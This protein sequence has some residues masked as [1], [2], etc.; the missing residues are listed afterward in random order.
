MKIINFTLCVFALLASGSRLIEGPTSGAGV[1]QNEFNIIRADKGYVMGG[2]GET[3]PESSQIVRAE[4]C[5]YALSHLSPGASFEKMGGNIH[6]MGGCSLQAKGSRGLYNDRHPF[7]FHIRK[8][9]PPKPACEP[10]TAEKCRAVAE[11]FGLRLGGFGFAFEDNYSQKGCYAYSSGKY[12]GIAFYGSGGSDAEISDPTT[13]RGDTYR[14]IGWDCSDDHA[15]VGQGACWNSE[16]THPE[17]AWPSIPWNP[18]M[19]VSL[20]ETCLQACRDWSS[21][22]GNQPCTGFDTRE[23]HGTS[24]YCVIYWGSEVTQIKP[25]SGGPMDCYK[26]KLS[27][28]YPICYQTGVISGDRTPKLMQRIQYTEPYWIT[29]SE[30]P[31]GWRP[32]G[33][34]IKCVWWGWCAQC[35]QNYW[36]C[37]RY[38]NHILH[39]GRKVP[40]P[41]RPI[42]QSD[43]PVGYCLDKTKM[44]NENRRFLML[45]KPQMGKTWLKK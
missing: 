32:S 12:A 14:P 15:L 8:N 37:D 22:P 2:L 17:F 28:S 1:N 11:G 31:R 3:C 13:K 6:E 29:P 35:I 5:E 43:L 36:S 23:Y 26:M 41:G 33:E 21:T 10:Y 9:D 38:P 16:S 42:S 7:E 20:K 18:E 44:G 40:Q 25:R 34:A 4:D 45:E 24:I 27:G 30:C 39:L 19:G